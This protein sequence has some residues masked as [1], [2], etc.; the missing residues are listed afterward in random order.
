M[1]I[2]FSPAIQLLG[3]YRF[4][5]KFSLI[6][7]AFIIPTLVSSGY[8]YDNLR[9]EADSLAEKQSSLALFKP[10]YDYQLNMQNARDMTPVASRGDKKAMATVQSSL[11]AASNSLSILAAVTTNRNGPLHS[12]VQNLQRIHGNLKKPGVNLPA[13]ASSYNDGVR[14]SVSTSE[15]LGL[16]AD[17]FGGASGMAYLLSDAL[18]W[19]IPALAEDLSSLRGGLLSAQAE[20]RALTQA[21]KT[22]LTLKLEQT[23]VSLGAFR[24][25]L[26]LLQLKDGSREPALFEAIK[27]ADAVDAA[28]LYA[29]KA[30]A[31]PDA[32]VQ[33]AAA[34]SEM[35]TAIN[36][37]YNVGYLAQ[38]M[39]KKMLDSRVDSNV[40]AQNILFILLGASTLFMLYL[41]SAFYYNVRD[42]VD[43]LKARLKRLTDGDLR[44]EDNA[45]SRD[46]IG[47]VLQTTNTLSSALTT[48]VGSGLVSADSVY[49]TSKR[50]AVDTADLAQRTEQSFEALKLVG[51]R[52]HDLTGTVR[53]NVENASTASKLA[54]DAADDAQKGD[55]AMDDVMDSIN[56]M[57]DSSVRVTDIVKVIQDIANRT[58]ILAINATIEA[59]RAG[60]AGRGFS[61]VANEVRKLSVRSAN[62]AQEIQAIIGE[63]A[64]QVELS[65]ERMDIAKNTLESIVKSTKRVKSIMGAI[66]ASSKE[67]NDGITR[68]NE[69]VLFIRGITEQNN[70]LVESTSRTAKVLQQDSLALRATLG[71]FR[72][73]DTLL[74][75]V[76]EPILP[77]LSGLGSFAEQLTSTIPGVESG[78]I[79]EPPADRTPNQPGGQRSDFQQF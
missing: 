23:R 37:V 60:E 28:L 48:I 64:Q 45:I 11:Q 56:R 38:P 65:V 79:F 40:Q 44:V 69:S 50:I 52:M 41:L 75:A 55:V 58:D 62:A 17:L 31:S 13:S 34:Y 21:E 26:K 33:D 49:T 51:E 12:D 78:E 36:A 8:V 9:A 53:Q 54:D 42:T 76:E 61:V 71:K 5:K 2:I 22:A 18:A 3:K 1:R 77:E 30:V 72:I 67:Q 10:L 39:L 20:G 43:L 66:A 25:T 7:A 73:E 14:Q 16:N 70:D 74:P 15:N 4:S 47:S 19:K 63:Q 32:L 24:H 46:E 35:T 27:K 57:R 6:A 68:T 29:S 59:A